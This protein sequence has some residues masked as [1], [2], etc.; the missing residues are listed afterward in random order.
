VI[1][2]PGRINDIL[3][4]QVAAVHRLWWEAGKPYGVEVADRI[5]ETLTIGGRYPSD[6]LLSAQA[7]QSHLQSRMAAA[8][9]RFDLLA[10]PTSGGLCKVIGNQELETDQG[11]MMYRLVLSW[12]SSLVN[13][14][15]CPAISIP[16]PRQD[17][18]TGVPFSLQ[19]IAPWWREDLLLRAAATLESGGLARSILAPV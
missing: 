13:T 1:C 15:G 2:P 17:Q 10:T 18:T 8:F 16:T 5:R 6:T 9:Q 14:S 4:P 7:W 12:F 3:Y 19:L 11:R